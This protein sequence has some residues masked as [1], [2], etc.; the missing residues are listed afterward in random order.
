MEKLINLLI[1]IHAF[2]GGV[3]LLSGLIALSSRKGKKLHKVAGLFFFYSMLGSG[4]LAIIVAS[5]PSH[6][7]PFLIAIG[8]FSLYFV[9]T[10][11]RASRFKRKNVSLLFDKLISFVMLVTAVLMIAIPLIFFRQIN[12]VLT[13]FAGVGFFFALRDLKLYRNPE[14]LR[15]KWIKLHLGK[16]IGGYISAATAFV[17]V[18]S[19][20]SG[21][22]GWFIPG[23]IGTFVIIYWLQKV[24]K[25]P[26]YTPETISKD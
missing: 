26:V 16:M 20:F 15:E 13:T 25:E 5:L 12:I 18:N 7:S 21:F 1:F 9:I 22:I 23:I 11:F 14:Q 10:G 6:E 3:S 2:L 8:V 19:F 24:E 4:I 17:V